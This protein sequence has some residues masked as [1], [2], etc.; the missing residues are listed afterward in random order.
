MPFLALKNASVA[1]TASA[2]N[3]IHMKTESAVVALHRLRSVSQFAVAKYQ[4][5]SGT[6]AFEL[7]PPQMMSLWTSF[8]ASVTE[9]STFSHLTPESLMAR[10]YVGL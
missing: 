4:Q 9:L 3:A 2:M 8:H 1:E 10:A 6:F 5:P 7:M